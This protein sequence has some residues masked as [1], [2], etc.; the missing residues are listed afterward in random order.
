[1]NHFGPTRGEILFRLTVSLLALVMLAV[2]VS[3]RGIP[4]D[5]TI[6]QALG[7][8]AIF[9]AS[10]TYWNLRAMRRLDDL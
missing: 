6:A 3:L 4:G 9:L 8:A 1:M 7:L 2:A 10:S 5:T